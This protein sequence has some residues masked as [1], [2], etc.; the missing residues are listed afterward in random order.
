ML[1]IHDYCL[2][3]YYTIKYLPSTGGD[4]CF[5]VEHASTAD[6]ARVVVYVCSSALG[7]YASNEEWALVPVTGSTGWC[8]CGK[9]I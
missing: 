4:I 2:P 1:L 7:P 6:Q 5:D 3:G 8:V 9:T